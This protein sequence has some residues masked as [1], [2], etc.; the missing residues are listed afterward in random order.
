[1]LP[2][3]LLLLATIVMEAFS[4]R[5]DA[6]LRFLH[7]QV[8][9]LKARVPGNRVILTP[10]ERKNLLRLG[11]QLNHDVHDVLSIV[12]VKTYKRWLREKASGRKA[13]KVGRPRVMTASLRALIKRLAKENVGW[14][15]RRIIGELKKLGMPASRSSVRRVLVDEG[16]LPDPDRHAPKG[17]TTPWRTFV[18]AHANVMVATD[19]FC[20]T[21]WT[22][23]GKRVAYALV[24]IHL[25]SRKVMVSPS[26]YNPDGQWVTQQARNV[27]MWLEDEKIK[28]THL[29]H[30]RD[31][32]FTESFDQLFQSLG[33]EI[34][35]TPFQAPVANC[36]AE[37]WIGTLKRECLNHFVCFGLRHFDYI[38]QTYVGYY[39]R[40][41]PHQSKDNRP[42]TAGPAHMTI[43]DYFR[44]RGNHDDRPS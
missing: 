22:P 10:D 37:S 6:R 1:M 33:V 2:K 32:K 38:V 17:V 44:L 8:A 11:S 35:K 24:F 27:A 16:V 5:R 23:L 26:T 43:S 36:Y 12:S 14:G 25:G 7:E 4:A 39:N 9:L 19:F 15:V 29:I 34:V 42:L 21:V 40:F 28:I 13:K 31:T 41:R 20:K 18:A 30:D 3:G